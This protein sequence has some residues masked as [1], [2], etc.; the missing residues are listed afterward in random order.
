MKINFDCKVTK[1]LLFH[2]TIALLIKNKKTIDFIKKL[3]TNWIAAGLLN[4][5][6]KL[7]IVPLHLIRF[8]DFI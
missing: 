2:H 4:E 7:S 1:N 6:C 3:I 5:D 8:Y